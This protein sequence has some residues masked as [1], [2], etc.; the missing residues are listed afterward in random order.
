M[1]FEHVDK[2]LRTSVSIGGGQQKLEGV[3]DVDFKRGFSKK[4]KEG[5]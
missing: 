2:K 4:H 3:E 1:I 5:R